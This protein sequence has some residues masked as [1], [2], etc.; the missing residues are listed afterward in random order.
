MLPTENVVGD[1]VFTIEIPLDVLYVM[2]RSFDVIV[3]SIESE[4]V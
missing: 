3:L 4:P 1:A 2:S